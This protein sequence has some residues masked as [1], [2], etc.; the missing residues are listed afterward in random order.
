MSSLDQTFALLEAAAVAGERCPRTSG[1]DATPNLKGS[2][3]CALA[4]E[5]RIFIEISS[6]NWRRVTILTGPHAGNST[7]PS[8]HSNAVAYRTV[9]KEGSKT[10]GKLD[11]RGAARRQ[12]P[13][14]PRFLTREELS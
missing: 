4:R 1:P 7:A 6:R 3:I 2:H 5:G 14:A 9:G 10:N 8:P 13:S 12:Q 11:D